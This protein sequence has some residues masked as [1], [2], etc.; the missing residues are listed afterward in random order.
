M[1]TDKGAHLGGV[2]GT[3]PPTQT[4]CSAKSRQHHAYRPSSP[5]ERGN[6]RTLT[7]PALPCPAL[8]P[9]TIDP[10][11]QCHSHTAPSLPQAQCQPA[12]ARSSRPQ[13]A[14]TWR[15]TVSFLWCHVAPVDGA[16]W[17]YLD[18]LLH[19]GR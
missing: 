2:G 10:P 4:K 19:W 1:A 3:F 6:I 7:G 16:V 8:S 5:G 9:V 17:R 13:V 14:E 15:R 11:C 12:A 18:M